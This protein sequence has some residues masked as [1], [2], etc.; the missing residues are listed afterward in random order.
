MSWPL[1]ST[2][3]TVS[4]LNFIVP[5]DSSIVCF[6]YDDNHYCI[7]KE[8]IHYTYDEKGELIAKIYYEDLDINNVTAP[9]PVT[10]ISIY[11]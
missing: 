9:C 7:D 6:Y 4:A 11:K 5:S 10:V 3:L 8:L 2:A 1:P